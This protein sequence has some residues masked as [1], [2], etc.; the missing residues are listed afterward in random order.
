MS[1]QEKQ[2]AIAEFCGWTIG[3]SFDNGKLATCGRYRNQGNVVDLPDYL[4]D[5]N[6][7]HEAESKLLGSMLEYNYVMALEAICKEA[8][9]ETWH[10]TASQRTDALLKTLGKL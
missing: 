3:V 8:K 6:A 5:L 7:I 9:N 1:D 2:I 4:H 10:A